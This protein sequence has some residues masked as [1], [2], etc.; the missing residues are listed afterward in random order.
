MTFLFSLQ[1]KTKSPNF[2]HK[3]SQHSLWLTDAPRWVL[4]ELDRV[5]FDMQTQKSKQVKWH[6]GEHGH[7]WLGKK[8]K[9]K[10]HL[11]NLKE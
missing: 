11:F 5:G 4:L 1:V 6:R 8:T 10:N 9:K 3:V 7:F 2:K